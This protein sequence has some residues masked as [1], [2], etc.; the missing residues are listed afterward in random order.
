MWLRNQG[1]NTQN[2]RVWPGGGASAFPTL[3]TADPRENPA[4]WSPDVAPDVVVLDVPGPA[5][6]VT[7]PPGC[8]PIADATNDAERHLVLAQGHARLRL[9]VRHAPHVVSP[10]LSIACDVSC[11][12]RLAAAIR[13]ER[14][15]GGTRLRLDRV[16]MPTRYQRIRFVHHL[17]LHDALE[18]GASARDLA[19]GLVFPNH[20]PL[21]GA[22]WKGSGERRHVLRLIADARRLVEGGYRNLLRHC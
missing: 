15:T 9:C 5:H 16:A 1:A 2:R 21:A 13:L 22:I 3:P 8:E 6:S 12:L 10:S 7:L 14:V 17:A 18:A 4:L 20:R 11:A 19:F